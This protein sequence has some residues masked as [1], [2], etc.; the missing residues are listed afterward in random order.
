MLPTRRPHRWTGLGPNVIGHYPIIRLISSGGEEGLGEAPVLPTWGGD[1]GRYFGE[2][3]DT[4][5]HL[6]NDVLF[7]S[8]RG[9]EVNEIP[10]LLDT[11]D[12]VVAGYPYAKAAI[13]MA[14]HDLLGRSEGRPVYEILGGKKRDG[15]L[16]SHSIG[17]MD[18]EGAAREARSAVDEGIKAIKIKVGQGSEEDSRVVSSVRNAIGD[19]TLLGVDANRGYKDLQSAIRAVE[20]MSRSNLMYVEQPM[21][22]IRNLKQ[23]QKKFPS[24]PVVADESAWTVEDLLDISEAGAAKGISVYTTKPGGLYHAMQVLD[25]CSRHALMSNING[26]CETGVGNAANIHLGIA[27]AT[28]ELPCVV[29]VTNIVGWEQTKVAG[30]FYTDDIIKDPFTYR[31]GYIYPPKKKAGLGVEL[32]ENKLDRYRSKFYPRPVINSESK[33]RRS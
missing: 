22:G 17:L 27:A 10:Y 13:D 31:D 14:L 29:P 23:I 21:E 5:I 11:M 30:V 33:A 19:K 12:Q 18:P 16:V 6:V 24:I 26:S 32:D 15:L 25:F 7:P 4:T 20:L 9:S 1:Y 3:I 2:D 28:L 8:I